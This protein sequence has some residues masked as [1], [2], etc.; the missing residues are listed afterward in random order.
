MKRECELSYI[1]LPY[2]FL[3]RLSG[4][5]LNRDFHI[6]LDKLGLKWHKLDGLNAEYEIVN[7]EKF[8]LFKIK[9]GDMLEKHSIKTN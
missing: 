7:P 5:V 2:D 8:M 9:H 3:F 6:F 4:C 1:N